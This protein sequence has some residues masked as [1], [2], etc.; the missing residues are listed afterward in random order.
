MQIPDESIDLIFTDPPYLKEYLHLYDW[1][2]IESQRI[3]K[4]DGFLLA[5]T[6]SYWK[7]KII[8]EACKHLDYY[9][10]IVVLTKGPASVI[11]ASKTL[12]KAKFIIA[13]RKKGSKSKQ[14]VM[15]HNVYSGDGPEKDGH[16]WQQG[17]GEAIYYIDCFSDIGDVVYDPFMGSGTTAE[18]SKIL[19]R[20]YI[21]AEIDFV[22]AENAINRLEANQ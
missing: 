2:A 10:D 14:R 4:P 17:L 11:W 15:V 3:L 16:E 6:P 9:T 1:L 13:Y 18:A 19:D 20:N 8:I 7:A 21:G 12:A 22:H 5:Y